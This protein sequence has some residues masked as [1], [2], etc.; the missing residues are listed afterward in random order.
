[1]DDRS[2]VLDAGQDVPRETAQTWQAMP[3][4]QSRQKLSQHDLIDLLN[5]ELAAYEECEGCHVT[6]IEV[7]R[8]NWKAALVGDSPARQKI[9]EQVL[10]E[11][12]EQFD[13]G[14]LPS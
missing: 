7:T 9:I 5:F 14:S 8:G 12:R 10:A 4:L 2:T 6:G 13:V 1:L 3:N 11:T